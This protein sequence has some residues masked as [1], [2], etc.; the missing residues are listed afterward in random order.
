MG[1]RGIP[2]G[3]CAHNGYKMGTV[4][5][6]NLMKV[7]ETNDYFGDFPTDLSAAEHH[8]II[9]TITS[10]YQYVGDTKALLLRI[11]DSK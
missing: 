2:D 11:I 5:T 9:Y 7:D 8:I 10:E 4:T 3:R 6:I 1:F